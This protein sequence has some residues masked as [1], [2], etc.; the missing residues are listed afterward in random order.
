MARHSWLPSVD[1]TPAC[2]RRKNS[3]AAS[4]GSGAAKSDGVSSTISRCNEEAVAP[5]CNRVNEPLI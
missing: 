5:L 3:T 1:E 2:G 4:R